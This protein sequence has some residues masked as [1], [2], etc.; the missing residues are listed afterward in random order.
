V[1]LI[2][3]MSDYFFGRRAETGEWWASVLYTIR[4]K[5]AAFLARGR[6]G[7]GQKHIPLGYVGRA[8]VYV[9]G[10]AGASLAVATALFEERELS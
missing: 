1:F 8:F 7:H 3:L 10:Y 2:G 4:S 9:V 5:L 6:A